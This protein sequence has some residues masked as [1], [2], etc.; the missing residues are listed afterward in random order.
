MENSQIISLVGA[1]G[2]GSL[3]GV[4]LKSFFDQRMG[5]KKML[6]ESRMKAYSGLTGRFV[7][8]FL[9][10]DIT[11]LKEDAL[12]WAKLGQLLSDADLLGSSDLVELLGEYKITV[13]NFHISLSNKSGEDKELHEKLTTLVG[14][15][16]TQMRKDLFLSS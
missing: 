5:Y 2:L 10:P 6:F 12:I 13:Y 15:I 16:H 3:L 11:G 9:E 4:F 1:L 8:H 14:Q 7:N